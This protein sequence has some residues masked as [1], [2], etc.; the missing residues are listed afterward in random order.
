MQIYN[1]VHTFIISGLISLKAIMGFPEIFADVETNG[2][3]HFSIN[4][5]QKG[6]FDN[7]NSKRFIC[8]YDIWSYISRII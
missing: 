7:P 6:S 8:W 2:F 4:L 3:F 5:K 1:I